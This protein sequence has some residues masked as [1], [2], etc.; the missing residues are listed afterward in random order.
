MF[1]ILTNCHTFIGQNDSIMKEQL[2]LTLIRILEKLISD[3]LDNGKI[4]NSV[5]SEK[6]NKAPL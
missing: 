3:L 5:S 1:G 2:I 6:N 4:D